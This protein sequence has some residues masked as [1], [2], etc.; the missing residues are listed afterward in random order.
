MKR[1]VIQLAGKTHVISLPSDWVKKYGIKK[2]DELDVREKHNTLMVST[3][4]DINV[5]QKTTVDIS[6]LNEEFI[7][8]IISVLHKVGYDEVEFFFDDPSVA[9]II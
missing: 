8:S 7:K 6:G 1:K 3:E 5:P 2:S 9:R 4:Q